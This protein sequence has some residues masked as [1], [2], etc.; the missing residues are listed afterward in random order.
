MDTCLSNFR[1]LFEPDSPHFG[2]SFDLLDTGRYYLLFD[3]LM[4]HW[5]QQ[6]PG[7]F[8]ELQY[9]QLVESQEAHTRQLLAFCGLQWNDACLQFENNQA[10]ATTASAVQVREPIYRSAMQRWRQYE[11]Q[12]GELRQVLAEAGVSLPQ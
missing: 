8:L 2:Y 1:Q 6:F 12:L 3:R 9:E 11:G 10:P 5:K 4:A 7:R